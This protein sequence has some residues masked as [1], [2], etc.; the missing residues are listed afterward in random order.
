MMEAVLRPCPA[1]CGGALILRLEAEFGPITLGRGECDVCPFA[2]T[3]EVERLPDGTY[4]TRGDG[5]P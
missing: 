3:V 2:V 5:R 4:E 1:N